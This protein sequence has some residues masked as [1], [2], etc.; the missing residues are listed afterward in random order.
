MYDYSG[1][2]Y[3]FT[4]ETNGF[5]KMFRVKSLFIKVFVYL[6]GKYLPDLCNRSQPFQKFYSHC[7]GAKKAPW[8]PQKIKFSKLLSKKLQNLKNLQ[9]DFVLKC[10]KIRSHTMTLTT[11][12]GKYYVDDCKPMLAWV[13]HMGIH[14]I[15][16]NLVNFMFS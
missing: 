2:I 11:V 12:K 4:N 6:L 14:E 16:A 7:Y 8:D 10:H 15:Y 1:F 13:F 3:E 5:H 9:C